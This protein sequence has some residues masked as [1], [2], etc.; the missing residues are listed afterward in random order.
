MP[1]RPSRLD[2]SFS[3]NREGL[4]QRTRWRSRRYRDDHQP[5]LC[6]HRHRE[7]LYTSSLST[8]GSP[9]TID[10]VAPGRLLL[11]LGTSHRLFNDVYGISMNK[12][13]TA[14]KDCV[15]ALRKAFRG[16][17]I[18]NLPGFHPPKAEVKIPIYIAGL[19]L[20][21]EHRVDG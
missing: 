8:G 5:Y 15:T 19:R 7:H 18:I 16:E 1:K 3:C 10:T 4:Q 20:A 21:E 14:M 6:R 12:P 9:I 17:P 2:C 13:V 11:G